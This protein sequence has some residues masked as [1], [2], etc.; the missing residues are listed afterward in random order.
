MSARVPARYERLV[1]K[2]A[3]AARTSKSDLV[4]RYDATVAQSVYLRA[5]S[6]DKVVQMFAQAGDYDRL[7]QHAEPGHYD[8]CPQRSAWN[9]G[10]STRC[11]GWLR[12]EHKHSIC[13]CSSNL[14]GAVGG[15]GI[16]IHHLV[17]L[18]TNGLY[19][20]NQP[21]PFITANDDCCQYCLISN[22]DDRRAESH[23][24]ECQLKRCGHRHL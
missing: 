23:R 8:Q 15:T 19:A 20:I 2:Q 17:N 6:G 9:A 7:C 22:H 16:D 24:L 12:F 4:A 18:S 3:R 13:R 5:N 21:L 14:C 11:S 1:A 10:A